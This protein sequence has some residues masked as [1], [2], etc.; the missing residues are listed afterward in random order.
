MAFLEILALATV[1]LLACRRYGLRSIAPLALLPPAA[2][3][4]GL[5][6]LHPASPIAMAPPVGFIAAVQ[7]ERG[8]GYGELIAGASLPGLLLGLFLLVD[9]DH[10]LQSS[11]QFTEA[12]NQLEET[13]S[14]EEIATIRAVGALF[15]RLV[16]AVSF[17]SVL[18]TAIVSYK[19]GHVVGKRFGLSLPAPPSARTWR[20]WDSLIWVL[21]GGTALWFIGSGTLEELGFNVVMAMLVLY[22]AQGF[23][24]ARHTAWRLGVAGF[25]EVLFYGALVASQLWLPLLAGVGLM[26]TW[27][28]WRRLAHG[29]QAGGDSQ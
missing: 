21:I 27:F 22:A 19:L 29:A 17:L 11:P 7:A 12:M 2:A 16:P 8:R 28:D 6:D 24:V 10:R 13:G 25:L 5:F 20:L 1:T 18:L 4:I 3:R 9:D 15:D 23:S 26:D 14:E